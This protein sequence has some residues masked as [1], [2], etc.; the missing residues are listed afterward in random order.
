MRIETL[1]LINF[2]CFSKLHLEFKS[3]IL[4]LHGPN[5]SGKTTILEALHYACYLR[6]FKTH[7]H[8]HLIGPEADGFSIGVGI[9]GPLGPDTLH[10]SLKR[11][12]KSVQLNARPVSS[13]K[14]LYDVYRVVTINEDDSAMIQGAPTLR[15]SFIDHMVLLIDPSFAV[16]SKKYKTILDNRN[17]LLFSARNDQD[18]YMLWTEQLLT[19]SSEIQRRRRDGLAQLQ[20]EVEKLYN[21]LFPT[22]PEGISLS[23]ETAKSYGEAE[24]IGSAEEL[25]E[26]YPFLMTHEKAQRRTL[27]GAH[28]DDL[29]IEYQQKSSKI[30]ASRGQQKLIVIVLKLAQIAFMKEKDQEVILLVDDFMADFDEKRIEILIP[31][32]VTLPSQLIISSPVEDFITRKLA[33][34]EFQSID[35]GTLL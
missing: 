9:S 19:V 34:Y 24:S 32:L 14:E 25:L 26:R 18:S 5:G 1:Q 35:L 4:F 13:Y 22:S 7:L 8:K 30:Y 3:S 23:Y 2:R 29:N 31:F 21:E 16:L 28:L 15:R 27:F 33:A 10:V 20:T 17:A 11:N 12:K 6:S